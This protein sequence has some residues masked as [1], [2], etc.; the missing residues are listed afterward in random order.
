[1]LQ[2]IMY[3]YFLCRTNAYLVE[4]SSFRLARAG[5]AKSEDG[6]VLCDAPM[7]H[8]LLCDKA[9]YSKHSQATIL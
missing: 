8:E 6:E 7:V 5:W 2:H 9:C 4:Y 3:T 1:M